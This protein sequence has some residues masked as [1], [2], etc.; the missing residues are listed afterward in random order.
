LSSGRILAQ[1]FAMVVVLANPRNGLNDTSWNP[2]RALNTFGKI[3]LILDP[4]SEADL[5]IL[6]IEY[7]K[8]LEGSVLLAK[9]VEEGGGDGRSGEC[10]VVSLEAP[11]RSLLATQDTLSSRQQDVLKLIVQGMSNKEIGRALGL[12]EGTV[13]IHV[14]ALFARL[15]VR[16]RSAVAVAGSRFLSGT[17]CVA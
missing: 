5:D 15:G 4:T 7:R 3:V 14:A 17:P 1:E 10:E 6:S 9:P 11:A 2:S 8:S 16:R 13:K 12:A